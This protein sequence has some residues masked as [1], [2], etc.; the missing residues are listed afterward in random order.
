VEQAAIRQFTPMYV[1]HT[2]Q[3][4]GKTRYV[5]SAF[6]TRFVA[7]MNKTFDEQI[8]PDRDTKKSLISLRHKNKYVNSA[9]KT[10]EIII[11]WPFQG[12]NLVFV[13][14]YL[15]EF[16]TSKLYVVFSVLPVLGILVCRPRKFDFLILVDCVSTMIAIKHAFYSCHMLC[17]VWFREL[18][19]QLFW[20]VQEIKSILHIIYL[21]FKALWLFTRMEFC[22]A[23]PWCS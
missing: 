16:V 7:P 2:N 13:D 23:I 15:Q 20:I 19:R 8:H 14:I 18:F 6:Y 11:K 9:M 17:G 1:L 12:P 5:C 4:E 3:S 22:I 10:C 21:N